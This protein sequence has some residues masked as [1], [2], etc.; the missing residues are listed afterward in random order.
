MAASPLP[1]GALAAVVCGTTVRQCDS[2]EDQSLGTFCP[3]MRTGAI[4]QGWKQLRALGS[5]TF[6][7]GL[8]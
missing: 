7:H 5:R 2:L 4:G 8:F 6:L 3:G 1:A